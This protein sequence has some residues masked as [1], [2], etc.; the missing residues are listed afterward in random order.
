MGVVTPKRLAALKTA[1]FKEFSAEFI[2]KKKIGQFSLP[3]FDSVDRTLTNGRAPEVG[4]VLLE[5]A[6]PKTETRQIYGKA[7]AAANDVCLAAVVEPLQF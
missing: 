6:F 2:Y 4:D 3:V 5:R 1:A 7:V